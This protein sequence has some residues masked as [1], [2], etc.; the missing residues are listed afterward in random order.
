MS[1]ERAVSRM[2]GGSCQVPLAAYAEQHGPDLRIQ[3]LVSSI[4]G[5]RRVRSERVGPSG[6]AEQLGQAVAQDLLDNGAGDIL[7]ELLQDPQ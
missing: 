2:L 6:Q 7:A 4:D 5:V 3:A 1:A